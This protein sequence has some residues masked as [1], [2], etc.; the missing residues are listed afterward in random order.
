MAGLRP[1]CHESFGRTIFA[2]W[3]LR[4]V[5]VVAPQF[6]TWKPMRIL[7]NAVAL[8]LR[9]RAWER[10]Y[11]SSHLTPRGE[12]RGWSVVA[13]FVAGIWKTLR[14]RPFVAGPKER[15]NVELLTSS[16]TRTTIP[17][18]NSIEH[19]WALISAGIEAPIVSEGSPILTRGAVRSHSI[20]TWLRAVD[21]FKVG[22]TA[23]PLFAPYTFRHTRTMAQ[24]GRHQATSLTR[25]LIISERAGRR[26]C[27]GLVQ[28]VRTRGA[29][30]SRGTWVSLA[31]L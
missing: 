14:W 4:A 15:L 3:N 26:A 8:P 21:R 29:G 23:I 20:A 18:C 22:A 6:V 30:G 31:I 2:S 1:N 5:R 17:I 10:S 27:P 19:K 13:E 12:G 28:Q 24:L 16:K 25:I 7:R 9:S 11:S